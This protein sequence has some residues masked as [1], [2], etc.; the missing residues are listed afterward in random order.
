MI[1]CDTNILIEFYKGNPAI[2]QALRDIGQANIA[3]SAITKAE[4]LF[5][6]R[7]KQE[8][9]KINK[10]LACCHCY[11]GCPEFCV[12][13]F[14]IIDQA[15]LSNGSFLPN[16]RLHKNYYTLRLGGLNRC[17]TIAC[18]KTPSWSGDLDFFSSV[19]G[20]FFGVQSP[21]NLC[22]FPKGL[23]V[24]RSFHISLDVWQ[25]AG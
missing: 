5:G 8:L 1:L 7:D 18:F 4:L 3:V 11:R 14:S 22:P 20:G 17:F 16:D 15:S 13:G 10:H 12:N 9:A 21:I 25:T 19:Q 23:V 2:I 6:A 24:C